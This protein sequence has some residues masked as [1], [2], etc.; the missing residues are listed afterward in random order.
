MSE[1]GMEDDSSRS[2]DAL[3]ALHPISSGTLPAT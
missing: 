1:A 2:A 3:P